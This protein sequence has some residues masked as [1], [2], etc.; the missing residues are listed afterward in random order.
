M[1]KETIENVVL[2]LSADDVKELLP[3]EDFN[4]EMFWDYRDEIDINTLRECIPEEKKYKTASGKIEFNNFI[5]D[6]KINIEDKIIEWN[7]D[8]MLEDLENE[9]K[10]KIKCALIEK[11]IEHDSFEFDFYVDDLYSI[12]WNLNYILKRSSVNW[13]IYNKSY[14]FNNEEWYWDLDDFIKNFGSIMDRERMIKICED[15][16][17]GGYFTLSYKSS[18]DEFFNI[19][20]TWKINTYWDRAIIFDSVY[21]SGG[22]DE[23]CNPYIINLWEWGWDWYIDCKWYTVRDVYWDI[24]NRI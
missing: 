18:I 14:E 9:L 6:W 17:Y 22:I 13:N 11:K 2:I 15:A 19:I 8:Y 3:N 16:F 1:K 12:N 23:E 24:I 5:E 7:W 10:N 20:S 21:W 4:W